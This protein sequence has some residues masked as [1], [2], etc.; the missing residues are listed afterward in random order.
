MI[1]AIDFEAN[2]SPEV[3]EVVLRA[4]IDFDDIVLGVPPP[5]LAGAARELAARDP[6]WETMLEHT[7]SIAAMGAQLWLSPTWP[8]LLGAPAQAGAG[9]IVRTELPRWVNL[10]TAA[11]YEGWPREHWP[12]AIASLS[13]PRP[14]RSADGSREPVRDIA[15]TWLKSHPRALW[16]EA[17]LAGADE[18]NWELL[19][20]PQGRA[21]EHRLAAQHCWATQN[22]SDRQIVTLPG[23][24]RH[25][26]AAGDSGFRNL[27][28]AG[29]WVGGGLDLACAEGAVMAGLQAARAQRRSDRHPRRTRRPRPG[30]ISLAERVAPASVM[31]QPAALRASRRRRDAQGRRAT[32]EGRP[33]RQAAPQRGAAAGVMRPPG[34]VFRENRRRQTS[35][36]GGTPSPPPQTRHG[37]ANRRPCGSS[38]GPRRVA[39][40]CTIRPRAPR[41]GRAQRPAPDRLPAR[42]AIGRRLY[43]SPRSVDPD[44]RALSFRPG[45]ARARAA[46]RRGRRS[47][48]SIGNEGLSD[49]RQRQLPARHRL[50]IAIVADW[51]RASQACDDSPKRCERFHFAP[52]LLDFAYQLQFAR[53]AMFRPSIGIGYNVGN[54]RNAMPAVLQPSLFAGYQGKL[55]GAAAGWSFIFPFPTVANQD[56]GH[57]GLAQP[58]L[59]ATT[60]CSSSSR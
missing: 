18:F 23:D 49:P 19:L 10:S 7:H 37:L 48:R 6:R 28:L 57:Q 3:E 2:E 44:G 51:V 29:D 53:Y 52:L 8:Q 31:R 36:Q 54:S 56:N 45:R 12:G 38:V 43:T 13:G 26:L 16:P 34:A 11:V 25:R 33:R 42:T 22:A 55:F 9:G 27:W 35:C 5:A 46:D 17:S 21:A 30:V 14:E 4:G 47:A 59:W 41:T 1:Q 32:N 60:R 24:P 15:E 40:H 50:R 20:D 58:A 39:A